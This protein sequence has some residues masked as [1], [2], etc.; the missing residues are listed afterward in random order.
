MI[1]ALPGK[2]DDS[3]TADPTTMASNPDE[4]GRIT[5]RVPQRVQETL[6]HA[7]D[8]VGA[9]LNQFIV[10][11]ALRE[12]ERVIDRERVI[13]LSSQDA[14]FLLKLLERPAAPNPR[15]A[16]ALRHYMDGTLDADNSVFEWKPRS[17]GV[18]LRKSR[19]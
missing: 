19:S 5:A 1:S 18:R 9:P 13:E 12:A 2:G 3:E 16:K 6:Q 4:R 11:A 15:L 10:Q 7:A 8:L 17:K 14:A